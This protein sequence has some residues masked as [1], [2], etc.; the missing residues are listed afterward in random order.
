M[1]SSGIWWI[2]VGCLLLGCSR[3]SSDEA[4]DGGPVPPVVSPALGEVG[5]VGSELSLPPAFPSPFQLPTANQTL[6]EPGGE[7]QFFTPTPVRDWESGTF[8]CVRADQYGMRLHEGIDIR[9]ISSDRRGEP[10]DPVVASADGVVGYINRSAGLSNYG[11]YV[12]LVHNLGGLQVY[13]LYA[14]LREVVSSLQIGQTVRLGDRIGTLGRTANTREVISRERAHLHFEVG[15]FLNDRFAEWHRK[16]YPK[17]SNDHG[18]YNGINL[19]GLDPLPI[20][21]GYHQEGNRFD[22][23]SHILHQPELCRV[24]LRTTQLNWVERYPELVLPNPVAEQEGIVAYEC[25]LNYTGI[26][27]RVVPRAESELTSARNIFLVAV[28]D[29]E[30]KVRACGRIVT[31]RGSSWALTA[32]GQ[33]LMEQLMFR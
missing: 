1:R 7:P 25:I 28:N 8:G 15:L 20:F 14:H 22:L 16:T 26:P 6:F 27:V 29:E 31:R 33:R 5:V 18:N 12:V 32:S 19:L 13:T 9:S 21:F 2:V 30:F 11:I 3:K 4:R 10:T 17:G 24:V 23:R